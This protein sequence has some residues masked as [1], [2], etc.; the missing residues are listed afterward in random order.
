MRWRNGKHHLYHR[1]VLIVDRS[2]PAKTSIR[3]RSVIRKASGERIRHPDP[4]PLLDGKYVSG[5]EQINFRLGSVSILQPRRLGQKQVMDLVSY[6]DADHPG[7]DFA[8][9]VVKPVKLLPEVGIPGV[10]GQRIFA[11]NAAPR[12]IAAV[13]ATTL[14]PLS[15]APG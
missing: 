11:R 9:Q 14:F 2:Q 3:V 1:L 5:T 10:G 15:I 6:R 4:G 7:H 8:P 12:T 13:L